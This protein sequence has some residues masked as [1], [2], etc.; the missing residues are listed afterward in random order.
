MS[1]EPDFKTYTISDLSK[2]FD[3][4][5]R[6]LR[7]YEESDLLSPKREGNKRIYLERDRVRLRLLLRGKRLGCT[8]SEIK[9]IFDLYETKS[10]EKGQILLLLEK[11]D[12]RRKKLQI[13][14]QDVDLALEEIERVYQKVRKSLDEIEAS[15]KEKI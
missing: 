3:V 5:P 13:Q 4:T 15:E 14:R 1:K 9:D 6:A 8:L 7:L 11:M 2:E 10:G 12:A